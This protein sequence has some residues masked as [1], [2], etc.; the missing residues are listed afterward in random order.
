MRKFVKGDAGQLAEMG[1]RL[2]GSAD[3]YGE[4]GRSAYNSINFITCHDGFTLNDMVSY[5][6]K[7]NEQNLENNN[8]GTNDNNSWN[9]GVEGDTTDPDTITLRKRL[10]KNFCCRLLFSAGTPMILGGDEFMRSQKGNNNAYCQDNT[11]SWFDWS[12]PEANRDI[13]N[14]FKKTIAFTKSHTILQRRKFLQGIDSDGNNM[15]DIQ[16]FGVDME[17]PNW[18][19]PEARTL[20]YML[21][22]SED[23][24]E[25]GDYMLFVIINADY[26]VQDVKLPYIEAKKWFRVID[27]SLASGMD[28]MEDGKEMLLDP[29]DL[30]IANPRSTVVLLGK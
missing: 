18:D 5:N 22:G 4:D 7:H 30:Y 19:D 20:C 24:S 27:T 9:C 15:P 25:A 10:I 12:L 28:F 11:L 21:D 14:F 2:T 13:F 8:D 29:F 6:Y 1:S 23:K 3:L 26:K 17:A 16:W